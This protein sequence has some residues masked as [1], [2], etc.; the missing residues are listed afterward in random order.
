MTS[1]HTPAPYDRSLLAQA[2]VV[3]REQLQEGYDTVLLFPNRRSSTG[4]QLLRI[5]SDPA[6]LDDKEARLPLP[7]LS[8]RETRPNGPGVYTSSAQ[9]RTSKPWPWRKITLC[10][11]ITFVLVAAAVA[12]GVG[13]TISKRTHQQNHTD[14]T[15]TTPGVGVGTLSATSASVSSP[16]PATSVD[17]GGSSGSIVIPA[18]SPSDNPNPS[19]ST[20]QAQPKIIVEGVGSFAPSTTA[21]LRSRSVPAV[22][23]ARRHFVTAR[24]LR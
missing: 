5:D 12:A 9:A 6:L 3:T 21:P 17:T 4:K 15:Q 1:I 18:S 8:P 16:A 24:R 22:S 2:P 19:A 10:L 7:E 13:A 20:D 11:L 14:S 23:G